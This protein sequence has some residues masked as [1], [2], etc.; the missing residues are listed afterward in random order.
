MEFILYVFS[1]FFKNKALM[2][3][4]RTLFAFNFTALL[5]NIRCPQEQCSPTSNVRKKRSSHINLRN[6]VFEHCSLPLFALICTQPAYKQQQNEG[7]RHVSTFSNVLVLSNHSYCV[8][9]NKKLWILSSLMQDCIK[10]RRSEY[11]S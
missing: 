9:R 8:I 6:T 1:L 11:V 7:A 2:V 3:S 10:M 5:R 4:R